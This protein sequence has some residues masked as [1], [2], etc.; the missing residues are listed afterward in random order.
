ML[1]AV[2]SFEGNNFYTDCLKEAEEAYFEACQYS[3]FVQL[4]AGESGHFETLRQ[5]W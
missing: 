2:Q 4:L 1:Y 3:K 5:S